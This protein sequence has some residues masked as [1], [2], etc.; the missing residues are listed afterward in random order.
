M[1]TYFVIYNLNSPGQ[2]YETIRT[3]LESLFTNP[4]HV[5]RST[6]GVKSSYSATQIRDLLQRF[7]DS[8]DMLLVIEVARHNRGT[9]NYPKNV[10]DW[11]NI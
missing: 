6:Y 1:K 3:V 9:Y 8:N 4:I 10:V 7:V 11:L 5:T 2:D